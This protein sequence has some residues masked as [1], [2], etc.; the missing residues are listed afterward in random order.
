SQAS[1]QSLP[2]SRRITG[3]HKPEAFVRQVGS[4]LTRAFSPQGMKGEASIEGSF[5]L[6]T[7]WIAA[8]N[9]GTFRRAR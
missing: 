2:L 6:T 7:V 1:S 5:V 4:L 9:I 8:T 3:G